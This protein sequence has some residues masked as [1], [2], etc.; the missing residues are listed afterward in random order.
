M[1][2]NFGFVPPSD[3]GSNNSENEDGNPEGNP[4]FAEIFKQFSGMGLDI[5][6]LIASLSG[7]GTAANLSR[8]LIRDISRKTLSAHGE[9]P[10]G[11]TD[12][13][14][15][16][17]A[18]TI[19]DLWVDGATT[20]PSLGIPENCA[21]GRGEWIAASLTGWHELA[22]PLIDGLISLSSGQNSVPRAYP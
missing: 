19:A 16:R 5:K 12:L 2:R 3:S 10:V 20:F 21:M 8:D 1:S 7:S 4:N 9:L 11:L 13:N 22:K 18:F 15:I 17:E 6:S 14:Q